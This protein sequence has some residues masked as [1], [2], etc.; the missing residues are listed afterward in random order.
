MKGDEF[1]DQ[2]MDVLNSYIYYLV[3]STYN[4]LDGLYVGKA[5]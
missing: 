5:R 3:K 4:C 2:Q 1:I